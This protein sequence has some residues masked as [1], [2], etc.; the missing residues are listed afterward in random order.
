MEMTQEIKI[1]TQTTEENLRT[2]NEEFLT[3]YPTDDAQ[4]DYYTDLAMKVFE[5]FQ[6]D[7]T[8]KREGVRKN[9]ATW[10]KNK[11]GQMELF[12]K[13]PYW[14][15]E[16][17]AIVFTQTETREISYSSASDRLGNLYNY[18]RRK[19][20]I[21]D[22]KDMIIGIYY[23]L[24]DL[25]NKP[26]KEIA[27]IS[28]EFLTI[29]NQRTSH[30]TVIPKEIKQILKVGTKIT[31]LV[32]KCY[33]HLI[34]D[35]GEVFDAT[36]IVD[37]HE[38]DN[39]SYR[40]F[41]KY[42]AKFADTLSE[43]TVKKITLV[44][45]NFLDFMTMSNGNSWS[46]C[47]F[48]NSNGI[49]HEDADSSY[50]GQYKQGCLSYAL[51]EP[52][53]LLYTLPATF[54]G[55]DYYRC[56]KLT[57]MCCQYQSG[58]LITGKCYPNN[59][60][61]LITR[62]RQTL[63]TIISQVEGIPNLWT[64]SKNVGRIEAFITTADGASHY[65]DYRHPDQKPTISLYRNLSI[66]LDKPMIIGH[67]AYCLH[68]GEALDHYDTSWLQCNKHRKAMRC[69]ACGR[70]LE[71][72]ERA[73]EIN[74]ELYCPDCVFYCEYHQQYEPIDVEHTTV[75]THKGNV[76]MC[77][78]GLRDMRQ[79]RDC[80]LYERVEGMLYADGE[81]YCTKCMKK[82]TKCSQCGKLIPKSKSR[83][84]LCSRC[85]VM[86]KKGIKIITNGKYEAGDCVLVKDEISCIHGT[87]DG[88]RR[89]YPNRIVRILSISHDWFNDTIRITPLD[90]GNWAWDPGCFVGKVVGAKESHIGKTIDEI[91]E[92]N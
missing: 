35:T 54:E 89:Y 83:K 49:F 21:D 65:E 48:I 1:N 4:V 69:A 61:G 71:D 75:C 70:N 41:D 28:D 92:E 55:T 68:C 8:F 66:D 62:Y 34:L 6:I 40:S 10:F 64:F 86:A 24:R 57:R 9:V 2:Q 50:H 63:Q 18:I 23:T 45:L 32:R 7:G 29:L 79:C 87:N 81:Y 52:S 91:L 74:G 46:S 78:N 11:Q 19:K 90:G 17:K 67:R 16:A 12:R 85:K 31:K 82:F 59:E 84:P 13:H 15:E 88:M 20:D 14:N 56:Q 39:R 33:E 53:L 51:D 47:H 3:K 60:N 27:T 44:S 43:L 5:E 30:I 22:N 26:E 77:R 38:P 76:V 37:E 72:D 25:Q 80:G 36:K 58:V 42:Y 73:I